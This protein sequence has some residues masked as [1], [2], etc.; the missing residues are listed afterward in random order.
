MNRI[1][2]IISGD[3]IGVGFRSWTRRQAQDLGLVGWVANRPDNTVEV[4]AEGPEDK[5]DQL[6]EFCQTGPEVSDV[7]KVAITRE[8]ATGEFINFEIKI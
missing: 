1:R 3:V 8:V 5:L 6:I 7:E 2:L 4:V